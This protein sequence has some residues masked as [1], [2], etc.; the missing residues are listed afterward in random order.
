MVVPI[1]TR[2]SD[3]WQGGA[4]RYGLRESRTEF[5]LPLAVLDILKFVEMVWANML[6]LAMDDQEPHFV[7]SESY[8]W[9]INSES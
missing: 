1:F 2:C 9:V 8:L 6:I 3:G 4:V 7:V 5:D